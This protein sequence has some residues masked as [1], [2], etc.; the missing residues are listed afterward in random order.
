MYAGDLQTAYDAAGRGRTRRH[1]RAPEVG[2]NAALQFE[3]AQLRNRSRDQVR[4][5]VYASRA[6]DA[7]VA[8]LIGAGIKP[9]PKIENEALNRRIRN[10]WGDF[11][12]EAPRVIGQ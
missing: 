9:L 2:P 8:N 4:Q 6:S 3:L 5:N 1:W 10:L 11:V 12:Q 7:M